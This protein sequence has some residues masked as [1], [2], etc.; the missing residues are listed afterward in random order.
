MKKWLFLVA[1]IGLC[2]FSFGK[3]KWADK[4]IWQTKIRDGLPEQAVL[5]Y[6]GNPKY[7]LRGSD[8]TYFYQGTIKVVSFNAS[9]IPTIKRSLSIKAQLGVINFKYSDSR[10]STKPKFVVDSF[11][12]PDLTDSENSQDFIKKKLKPKQKLELWQEVKN[13]QRLTFGMNI[14]AVANILGRPDYEKQ[15]DWQIIFYYG[16][17]LGCAVLEFHDNQLFSWSEPYWPDIEE[18]LFEEVKRDVS[19]KEPNAPALTMTVPAPVKG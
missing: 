19:E 7:E 10:G 4:D 12:Q 15:E 6:L 16:D 18:R 14:N 5:K 11:T 8:L 13:W 2:P 1:I 17:I 9:T 3:A